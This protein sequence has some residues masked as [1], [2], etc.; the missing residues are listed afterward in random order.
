MKIYHKEFCHQYKNYL[1]GYTLHALR[2]EDLIDDIYVKGFLPFTGN[3]EIIN[4]FY[5]ARSCRVVL[6]NFELSSENRRI[7]KKILPGAFIKTKKA[8]AAYIQDE[9][10]LHFCLEY[11]NT[12]HGEGIFTKERLQFV[13]SFSHEVNVIKY[14]D[15]N[16]KVIAYV[17]EAE[18]KNA[19]QY[20]FSFYDINEDLPSLGLWLMLDGIITAK[21]KKLQYYYLGTVYGEK[22]LYKTNFKSLEYW[23]GNA[24]KNNIAALKNLARQ[25]NKW[26]MK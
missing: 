20:W 8:G 9:S 19:A 26:E 2:E 6:E 14:A 11:F 18:G 23:D 3:T 25:D 22:A 10:F 15:E 4:T 21:E 12:R 16:E 1:F 24:W 5:M 17:I 13:L 7:L